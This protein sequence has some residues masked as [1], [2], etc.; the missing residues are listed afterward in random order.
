MK[1]GAGATR[2]S[3]KGPERHGGYKQKSRG[4]GGPTLPIYSLADGHS[5]T[6]RNRTIVAATY[7]KR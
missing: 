3:Q 6:V 1:H 5:Q 4:D 2:P 7:S